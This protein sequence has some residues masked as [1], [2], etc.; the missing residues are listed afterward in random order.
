MDQQSFIKLPISIAVKIATSSH[1]HD[2]LPC[3]LHIVLYAVSSSIALPPPP[4]L[5]SP[6][7]Y[8]WR[9]VSA[10]GATPTTSSDG[11]REEEPNGAPI[12]YILHLCSR[13][14]EGVRVG[15]GARVGGRGVRDP[16]SLHAHLHLD[17]L[18]RVWV[19]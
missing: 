18:C 11:Q 6:R 1:S 3:L 12:V 16:H 2:T 7:E 8:L 17:E 13:G 14:G 15:G 10:V 5:T 9:G 19:S 4:P